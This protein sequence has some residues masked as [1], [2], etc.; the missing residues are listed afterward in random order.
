MILFHSIA[1]VGFWHFAIRLWVLD[2]AR[3]PLV[4]I[5]LWG[6]ALYSFLSLG[7]A[8]HVFMGLEA[9]LALVLAIINGYRVPPLN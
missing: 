9:A 7:L 3:V 6:L 8:A 2:G 5:G 1:L 4:F